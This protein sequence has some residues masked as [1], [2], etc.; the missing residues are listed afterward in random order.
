[1]VVGSTGG[2]HTEMQ[3]L[4]NFKFCQGSWLFVKSKSLSLMSLPAGWCHRSRFRLQWL[5]VV[6]STGGAHTRLAL[7]CKECV[8][9]VW[10]LLHFFVHFHLGEYGPSS[11]S[12]YIWCGMVCNGMDLVWTLLHFF[13]HFYFHLYV[14][15]VMVWILY[16]PSFISS[17]TST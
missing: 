9:G 13:L 16:G 14:W 17:S 1:M 3:I 6:G 12:M 7:L 15:Y 8:G 10:T 2:A 11:I 4:E 5:L